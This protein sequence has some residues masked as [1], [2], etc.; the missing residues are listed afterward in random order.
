MKMD[1]YLK[2]EEPSKEG[3]SMGKV[4]KFFDSRDNDAPKKT[5]QSDR[6]KSTCGVNCFMHNFHVV[7]T[8]A[9]RVWVSLHTWRK[10]TMPDG[11]LGS[12]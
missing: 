4:G 7:S 6:S 12:D 11:C 1:Y 2:L 10:E 9:Q 8:Q 5:G 3:G